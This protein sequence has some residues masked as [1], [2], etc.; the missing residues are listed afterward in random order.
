M[1]LLPDRVQVYLPKPANTSNRN[2]KQRRIFLL[3]EDA[4]AQEYDNYKETFERK[5]GC[6]PIRGPRAT[7]AR[8][9][10]SAA[11]SFTLVRG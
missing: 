1:V 2:R 5:P 3:Y 6:G 7:L 8:V 4:S 9:W 10:G 11:Q